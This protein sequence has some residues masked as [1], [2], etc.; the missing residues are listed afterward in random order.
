[1]N[2]ICFSLDRVLSPQEL[3]SKLVGIFP[4]GDK[5]LEVINRYK[6]ST[7]TQDKRIDQRDEVNNLVLPFLFCHGITEND[8]Y[9]LARKAQITEGASELISRLNNHSWNVYCITSCYRQYAVHFTQRLNI[10]SQNVASVSYPKD[11]MLERFNKD[12]VDFIKN[13]KKQIVEHY[14]VDDE[15]VD[16][17]MTPFYR[18]FI[19]Q[20]SFAS[21]KNLA[22]SMSDNWK[23]EALQK[24]SEQSGQNLSNWI[25][26]GSGIADAAL[27]KAVNEA[28]GLAVAFNAKERTLRNASLGLA[29]INLDVLWPIIEIW[30]SGKRALV[31]NYVKNVDR[32]KN[33]ASSG[34]FHWLE[35]EEDVISISKIH[36]KT[37]SSLENR[38]GIS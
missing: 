12:D 6:Y 2:N 34:I 31:E 3:M 10:F 29:S 37:R 38:N 9:S 22:R 16:K 17:V 18:D 8:L 4:E 21:I 7:D 32:N 28:E 15:W 36:E 19:P 1:M 5:I 13:I 35:T 33:N 20:T 30:S 26:V 23:F 14:P 27:L 24:H 25:V 11:E